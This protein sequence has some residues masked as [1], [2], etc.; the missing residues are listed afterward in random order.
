MI[1]EPPSGSSS[2]RRRLLRSLATLP[3]VPPGITG[4]LAAVPPGGPGEGRRFRNPPGSPEPGGSALDWITFSWRRLRND[5]IPTVLPPGHVLPPGEVRAGLERLGARDGVTWLGHASFLLRLGGRTLVTD[6]F[7]SD[8]ATPYPPL[9]PKR[10][11]P[12]GLR[13]RE[14]PSA[15]VVLLSHNHY[16]HLDLPTLAALPGRERA[17]LVTALGVGRYLGGVRF[18]QAHELGWHQRV[19]VRGMAITALPAIHFSKRGLFDRDAT[20]WCGF[21]V[22]D[23]A[24]GR[25]LYFAG[26]TAYGP[27]FP[28]LGARYPAPDLALVPIGAYAPRDMMKG[29]HCT[30]EEGLR[31]GLDMGAKAMCAMHWGAIRLTDE[32]SFEPPG[33]FRAAAEAAGVGPE[34]AWLLAVG[35]TRA[36]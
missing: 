31:L 5:G 29:T 27:V 34:R 16:D 3:W 21:L 36:F 4:A 14:L 11:A 13:P 10:F 28:E 12:P 22:E 8:H 18:G 2:S 35:E 6:P 26:D 24:T 7:L 20:L 15:D 23:G 9:G 30:P 17:V 25:R 1:V 33:R 19:E 32:D